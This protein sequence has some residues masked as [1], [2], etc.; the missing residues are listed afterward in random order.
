MKYVDTVYYRELAIKG[1]EKAILFA[2]GAFTNY[3]RPDGS[4]SDV[5]LLIDMHHS[6]PEYA[7]ASS[8]RLLIDNTIEEYTNE[9]QHMEAI[10][11][12][13]TSRIEEHK[14]NINKLLLAEFDEDTKWI[15]LVSPFN[16]E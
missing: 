15:A 6:I 12:E 3:E 13:Y 1:N 10:I 9:I 4:A 2:K 8:M 7:T 11:L 5:M 14:N 16:K